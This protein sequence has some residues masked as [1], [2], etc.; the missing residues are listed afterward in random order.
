MKSPCV[1]CI[2]YKLCKSIEDCTGYKVREK[3]KYRAEHRSMLKRL[4]LIGRRAV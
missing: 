2:N 1:N 3:R 4:N